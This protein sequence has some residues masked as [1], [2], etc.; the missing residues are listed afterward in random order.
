MRSYRSRN[1]FGA[2]V[3]PESVLLM[4]YTVVGVLV[5]GGLDTDLI[6]GLV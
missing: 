4:V 1:A 3:P 5:C 2:M 6:G